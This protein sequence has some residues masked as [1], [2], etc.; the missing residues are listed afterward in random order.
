MTSLVTS[1]LTVTQR[2][3][4]NRALTLPIQDIGRPNKA[5]KEL[6]G[7]NTWLQRR[8]DFHRVTSLSTVPVQSRAVQQKLLY[9]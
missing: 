4:D 1:Q 3:K 7:A 2:T 9:S 8:V 6:G 5:G